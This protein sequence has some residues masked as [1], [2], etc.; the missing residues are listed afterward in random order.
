[1]YGYIYLEDQVILNVYGDLMVTDDYFEPHDE[2]VLN[3]SGTITSDGVELYSLYCVVLNALDGSTVPYGDDL[4]IDYIRT[5]LT[6]LPVNTWMLFTT[7]TEADG[8][9][10]SFYFRTDE[11]GKPVAWLLPDEGTVTATAGALVEASAPRSAR[12]FWKTAALP[13]Q[14][15]RMRDMN[16]G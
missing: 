2:S 12:P 9:Y 7:E 6:R 1:M 10:M 14:S 16:L 5:T 15:P 13:S 4:D 8:E 11:N 3:V